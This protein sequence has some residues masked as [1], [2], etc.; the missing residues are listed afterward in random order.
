MTGREV[1]FV[2]ATPEMV[3]AFYGKPPASTLRA[4]AAVLD[5]RVIGMGGISYENGALVLFSEAGPEL[6]ARRRDM[7]RA[8]RFL[9][10]VATSVSHLAAITVEDEPAGPRLLARLGFSPADRPG[11]MLKGA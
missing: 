4:Y 9:E 10:A 5:G 7:V 8:F 1:E 3:V 2:P 6:K 11:L